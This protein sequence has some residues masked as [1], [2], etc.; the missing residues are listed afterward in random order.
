MSILRTFS[1]FAFA[2]CI[3]FPAM[4]GTIT[5]SDTVAHVE[6]DADH[7]DTVEIFMNVT[8]SG[9]KLDRIYAVRSPI[10]K[11]GQISG[12][13]DEHAAGEHA[14]HK[15]STAVNIPAGETTTLT[16]EGSHLELAELKSAPKPGDVVSVTLYFENAGPVKVQVTITEEDH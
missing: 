10:A 7:G 13:V 16:E 1:A 3:A 11:K 14:D 15:L 6:H 8:N 4:A 9:G 12:G 2:F 5:I